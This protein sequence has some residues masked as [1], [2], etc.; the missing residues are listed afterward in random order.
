M[1]TLLTQQLYHSLQHHNC[2]MN[3]NNYI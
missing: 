1:T 2:R 3:F